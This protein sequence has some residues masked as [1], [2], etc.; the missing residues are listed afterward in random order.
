MLVEKLKPWVTSFSE[1][2][3]HQYKHGDAVW[4]G[5][6]IIDIFS[7]PN[8]A[9]LVPDFDPQ[10]EPMLD[11]VYMTVDDGVGLNHLALPKD[12]YLKYKE[13]FNLQKGMVILAEGR[14]YELDMKETYKGK[15][16]QIENHPE[17][18]IRIFCWKIVPLPVDQVETP[19]E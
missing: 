8:V 2:I 10:A 17:G 18:T 11:A 7:V 9:D 6:E 1:A 13:L 4:V 12:A 3:R 14:V 16:R 5:G 19:S 15:T